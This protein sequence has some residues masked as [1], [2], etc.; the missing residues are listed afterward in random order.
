MNW[1]NDY[2]LRQIHGMASSIAKS[3]AQIVLHKNLQDYEHVLEEIDNVFYDMGLDPEVIEDLEDESIVKFYKSG[4]GD[5]SRT[6]LSAQLFKEKAEILEKT[7]DDPVFIESLY[8][9]A[10]FLFLELATTS[11]EARQEIYLG[12]IPVLA[13]RLPAETL[14]KK[15]RFDLYRFF[16]NAGLYAEAENFLHPL[17]QSAPKK[18]FRE[19]RG[20][21]LRLLMKTDE[22]LENGKLPRVECEEAMAELKKA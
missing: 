10:L 9:K 12:P 15:T 13:K 4:G 14:E 22:E 7:N 17:Y 18:Y 21:Y 1:E 16:E 19:I 20:F 6:L 11:E 8:R 5:F 2:L 3:F